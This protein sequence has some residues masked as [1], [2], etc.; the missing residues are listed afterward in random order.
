MK[1]GGVGGLRRGKINWMGWEKRFDLF[2]LL[3]N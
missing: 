3:W 1:G 2:Q